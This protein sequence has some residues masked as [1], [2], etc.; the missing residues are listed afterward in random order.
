MVPGKSIWSP[1]WVAVT[2]VTT[3]LLC[4][5][6]SPEPQPPRDDTA[7]ARTAIE[8]FS[9]ALNGRGLLSVRPVVAIGA[10]VNQKADLAWSA[11]LTPGKF[12]QQNDAA[13]D[14]IGRALGRL[15]PPA[16]QS[17]DGLGVADLHRTIHAGPD[18]E[19]SLMV[20]SP[21]WRTVVTLTVP[22]GQYVRIDGFVAC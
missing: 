19:R 8:Q 5:G 17:G 18:A 14:V 3:A 21:D 11:S 16:Q 7:R 22:R 4:A 20:W 15:T 13:D 12:T 6:C 9:A 2:A 1:R 10:C